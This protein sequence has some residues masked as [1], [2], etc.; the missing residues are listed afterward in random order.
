MH[1]CGE[2]A[3]ADAHPARVAR[4][5]PRL[6]LP[7]VEGVSNAQRPRACGEVIPPPPYRSPY[8]SPYGMSYPEA[9]GK[10]TRCAS[11]GRAW[12]DA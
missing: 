10:D 5:Q 8:A 3:V 12:T 1:V 6:V 11:E 4:H 9:C 7:R 2:H